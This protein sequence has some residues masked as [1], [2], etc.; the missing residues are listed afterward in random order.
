MI[1]KIR[2]WAAT[3]VLFTA[4]ALLLIK[5]IRAM[6]GTRIFDD[7]FMFSR[8]ADNIINHGTFGWNVGEKTFGCTSIPYVFAVVIAKVLNINDAIATG[9][10][11]MLTSFMFACASLYLIYKIMGRLRDAA[12]GDH[13]LD[14]DLS[15]LVI[16]GIMISP[17][18]YSTMVNGMDTTMAI[19]SNALLIY[20]ML[21]Y[22]EKRSVGIMVLAA[23]SAY[24]TF[25]VR[26]DNGVYATLF[27]LLFMVYK[28]FSIKDMAKFICV[29]VAFF[30]I[31]IIAKQV[32]FG[33][34]LPLSFYAK[35]SGFYR[36]YVN[37]HKWDPVL[38][39][40]EFIKQFGGLLI[41]A[42]SFVNKDRVKMLGVFV[43]PLV[44]TFIYYFGV[45]QIMGFYSRYY[46]PSMPF[47]II[48][49]AYVIN[50]V[51][52]ESFKSGNLKFAYYAFL[53]LI[54][55]MTLTVLNGNR[56]HGKDSGILKA[57]GVQSEQR[58]ERGGFV[59]DK[60]RKLQTLLD[61]SRIL[62]TFPSIKK[63]MITEYGFVASENP[64]VEIIDPIALH[65]KE[66]ALNGWS[67][68]Y[69]TRQ[70]PEI[71][72]LHE[73]YTWLTSRVGK[74]ARESGEYM[75]IPDAVRFGLMIRKDSVALRPENMPRL[76]EIINCKQVA[77][78][79]WPD[80]ALLPRYSGVGVIL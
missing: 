20:M 67:D 24:F 74:L 49:A 18:F 11:L 57:A 60:T 76:M 19:F 32:Y 31:D 15:K 77:D 58:P 13:L 39:M 68:E 38:Y 41:I 27:P 75:V 40:L 6:R 59:C 7:A 53:G 70:M 33:N 21:L 16:A 29:L 25:L 78:P 47:I 50:S 30:A 62:K 44:I 72:W 17:I 28:K 1:L 3:V 51:K 37:H 79:Y 35:S 26:P 69:V 43:I 65:N 45:V 71:I 10:L 46:I 34:P 55:I 12:G 54:L 36:G 22:D 52:V 61:F 23:F 5:L 56:L 64:G 80:D 9:T 8:Y 4:S 48:A 66:L 63:V 73:D 2:Q 14:G 42:V